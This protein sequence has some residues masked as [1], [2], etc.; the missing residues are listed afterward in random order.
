MNDQQ[1][2]T[3]LGGSNKATDFQPP[4]QN[5]QSNINSSLQ[6]T[7]SGLQTAAN[8]LNGQQS[9]LVPTASGSLVAVAPTRGSVLASTTSA[10]KNPPAIA[11]V[12]AV[13]VIVLLG[14]MAFGI[15]KPHK[16]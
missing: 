15:L 4:T 8:I 10:R 13:I 6:T 1:S 5:P 11:W 12:G 3:S 14:I 2:G 9:I 16:Y 7:D